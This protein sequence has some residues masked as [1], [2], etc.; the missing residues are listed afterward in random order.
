MRDISSFVEDQRKMRN[1]LERES[2][3]FEMLIKKPDSF[4]EGLTD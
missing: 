3:V 4:L 1:E 2:G